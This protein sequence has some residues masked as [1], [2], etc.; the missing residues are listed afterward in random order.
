MNYCIL[1]QVC[2]PD[3]L[4]DFYALLMDMHAQPVELRFGIPTSGTQCVMMAGVLLMQELHA[5]SLGMKGQH[6]PI[7]EHILAKAQEEFYWIICYAL[8]P[9]GLS[10]NV[11]I[12]GSTAITVGMGKMQV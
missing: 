12:M 11:S 1:L 6:W 7:R 4:A 10:F 9:K 3:F 8:E 2:H 5:A